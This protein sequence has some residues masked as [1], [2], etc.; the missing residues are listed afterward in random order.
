MRDVPSVKDEIRRLYEHYADDIYQYA[1]LTLWDTAEAHDVV[2]EVFFR[3]FQAWERFRHDASERTW[4]MSIARNYLF[5]VLR[6]RRGTQDFVQTYTPQSPKD[7]EYANTELYIDIERVL[8]RL[9]PD[10]RQVFILRHVKEL[11]VSDTAKI[12]G[13][14][15][16]KVRI[17]DFRA[18]AKLRS[19]LRAG[20][21]A[22]GHHGI[23]AEHE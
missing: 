7:D 16:G 12:L 17:T 14:S 9:K 11:P 1:R 3:A 15:P 18:L 21:E 13:W 22:D 23:Q 8:P 5:D 6:K 2:Q 20:Q 19:E 4:L 10:H